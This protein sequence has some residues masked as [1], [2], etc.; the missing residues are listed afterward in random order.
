MLTQ[1]Q[2]SLLRLDLQQ[3]ANIEYNDV[4]NEQLDHYA[5]LTEAKMANG[6][7]FDDASKWAWADMG[8]G[9][10]IQAIQDDYVKNIQR[11][12]G[13]AHLAVVKSYF[14]WPAVV[15][16]ALVAALIYVIVPL[17]STDFIE[18]FFWIMVLSPVS[19]SVWMHRRVRHQPNNSSAIVHKFLTNISSRYV[20]VAQFALLMSGGLI[21][22]TQRTAFLQTH[23]SASAVIC[24]MLLLYT[25]SFVHLCRRQFIYKPE[26]A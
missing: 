22:S 7:P 2:L 14:R 1:D 12:V 17:V 6:C 23:V 8:S 21:D 9:E 15:T 10:G 20:N 5:S 26:A 18:I 13:L 11:Q 4:L 3:L 25:I 19:V 16:T 24:M